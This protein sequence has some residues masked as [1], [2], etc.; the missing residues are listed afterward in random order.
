MW[1]LDPKTIDANIT[2][3]V[4]RLLGYQRRD[5]QLDNLDDYVGGTVSPLQ[6]A[7]V[8]TLARQHD[9]ILT[10]TYLAGEHA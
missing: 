10:D 5:V 1:Q 6:H 8:Q 3:D 9:T 2:D 4:A 7:R